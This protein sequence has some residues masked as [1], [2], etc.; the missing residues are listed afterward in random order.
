MPD[1]V[2]DAQKCQQKHPIHEKE[3]HCINRFQQVKSLGVV[4]RCWKRAEA[5]FTLVGGNEREHI[6]V[7]NAKNGENGEGKDEEEEAFAEESLF[8]EVVKFS[9]V[10][11]V[12]LGLLLV[13]HL[14]I[15]VTVQ[16]S[17]SLNVTLSL[18]HVINWRKC[19]EHG[20]LAGTL[21]AIAFGATFRQAESFRRADDL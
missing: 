7:S 14:K 8:F 5:D 11:L 9:L 17:P 12:K 2:I 6:W 21:L 18:Q 15:H 13:L 1:L 19:F 20:R 16:S 10:T 3:H 4:R